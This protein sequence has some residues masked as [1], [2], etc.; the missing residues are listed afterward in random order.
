PY[1]TNPV[2]IALVGIEATL[3]VAL[4][5][6]RNPVGENLWTTV[7]SFR[8][9]NMILL[10]PYLGSL[11]L[12]YSPKVAAVVGALV[13]LLWLG[14]GLYVIAALEPVTWAALPPGP[15]AQPEIALALYLKPDFFDT[16]KWGLGAVSLATLTL[17]LTYAAWR[18]RRVLNRFARS[19][20]D[21][22]IARETFGRYV[23]DQVAEE[24]IR[25]GGRVE[26]KRGVA[27]ILV[28]DI[29]DFSGYCERRSP[30]EILDTMN[31]VFEATGALV[32]AR[33]GAVTLFQ[34]DGF[35]ASFNAPLEDPDHARHAVETAR[36]IVAVMAEREFNG[37]RLGVRVGVA[38]GEIISGVC[39]SLSQMTYSTYGET[40][41][42]AAR[43]QELAK[44]HDA[45]ILI[46]EA[47]AE[48]AREARPPRP[49]GDLEVRGFSARR[50]VYAPWLVDAAA[51]PPPSGAA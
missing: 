16:S 32:R 26:P 49:I 28:A 47:T 5:V 9:G 18:S 39:G 29:A 36:A 10:L 17:L 8:Q 2:K 24:L 22:L 1:F 43:L 3:I 33:G 15:P 44:A 31:A 40:V 30:G 14:A 13:T 41:N 25:T 35:V 27:T 34:G 6:F 46:C 21:R 4:I 23:P 37:A 19:E 7:Q 20:R 51:P 45:K 50:R 11:A 12:T 42:L 48:A 38:T